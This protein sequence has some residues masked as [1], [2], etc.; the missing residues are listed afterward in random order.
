MNSA[1]VAT[2]GVGRALR[3]GTSLTAAW[4]LA[5]LGAAHRW[6]FGRTP[7]RFMS[8]NYTL[9]GGSGSGDLRP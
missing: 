9:A 3:S 7:A 1:C 8:I 6:T 4:M 2:R 5:D